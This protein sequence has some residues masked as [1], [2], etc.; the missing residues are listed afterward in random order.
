MASGTQHSLPEFV[1][2]NSSSFYWCF[3]F[4]S[5]IAG[6]NPPP[7]EDF[8]PRVF[9][10]THLHCDGGRHGECRGKENGL[11]KDTTGIGLARGALYGQRRYTGSEFYGEARA[12]PSGNEQRLGQLMGKHITPGR[13]LEFIVLFLCRYLLSSERL[14]RGRNSDTGAP[15]LSVPSRLGGI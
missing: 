1:A 14:G 11:E 9:W 6:V 10:N 8:Y 15:W 3:F 5:F 4:L 2:H 7:L 12:N 13:L